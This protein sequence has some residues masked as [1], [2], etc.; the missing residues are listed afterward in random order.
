[1]AN[2]DSLSTTAA[3]AAIRDEVAFSDIPF[4]GIV[5]QS[6]AGVYV[7]LDERFMYANDTFAAMFGYRRDEFLGMRMVDL[8]T[9][10]SIDEVMRNYR[11]R[12]SGEVPAIH[13]FTK[14]FHKDGHVVHLELH[15]SRVDCRGRPAL[16]GVAIDVSERVQREEQLRQSRE[17]L[18]ELAGYVNTSREEQRAM[19]AREVHDVLGG[20]LTSIK[21]DVTRILRRA[22][23]PELEE[24]RSIGNDLVT[25]VQET[26]D[27]ARKIS[28]E[29]RPRILDA[30]GLIAAIKEALDRFGTRHGVGTSFTM[31]GVEPQLSAERTIQCYRIFQEALTNI[32]RHANART[33]RVQLQGLDDCLEMQ[34]EDDG[35]GVAVESM[36]RGGIGL[37]SM[38]E[39]ARE[40][41]GSL[42]L[43]AGAAGGTTVL[44]RVPLIAPERKGDD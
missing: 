33:V 23:A 37:F 41:G 40:I 21:M 11:L 12:I 17:Q 36:R 24:I 4:F 30:M 8:V 27:T 5:E 32:A 31:Q 18:R 14:C 16:C 13:Y 10:D 6:L 28:D 19:F 35:R 3:S 25:L 20:M 22:E 2:P 42:E 26:I 38:A 7:V 9:P 34:V 43:K 44:L 39:R 15:A 29:L 1:M